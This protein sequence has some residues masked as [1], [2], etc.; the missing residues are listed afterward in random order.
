MGS[1][2][3]RVP[4]RMWW[5]FKKR[6]VRRKAWPWKKRSI[7]S[8]KKSK[9]RKLLSTLTTAS[10]KKSRKVEAYTKSEGQTCR[11]MAEEL[12]T[13]QMKSRLLT[14][15]SCGLKKKRQNAI[16]L[17]K[18]TRPN[19]KTT[20]KAE[21]RTSVHSMT[22]KMKKW[23]GKR[24]KSL[25]NQIQRARKKKLTKIKLDR[26]ST[27][28]KKV[29]KENRRLVTQLARVRS[30]SLLS[31]LEAPQRW[32]TH[33]STKS[34]N[35]A[36]LLWW[37]RSRSRSSVQSSF[38]VQ[39]P[40]HWLKVRWS[41]SNRKRTIRKSKRLSSIEITLSERDLKPNKSLRWSPLEREKLSMR[42]QSRKLKNPILSFSALKSTMKTHFLKLNGKHLHKWSMKC[43]D[44]AGSRSYQQDRRAHSPTNSTCFISFLATRFQ[45]MSFQSTYSSQMLFPTWR[46]A[47]RRRN[48]E[49][50]KLMQFRKHPVKKWKSKL[51]SAG[52]SWFLS[53]TLNI[54]SAVWTNRIGQMKM[55]YNQ[56]IWNV[57]NS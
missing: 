5:K 48:L 49:K 14:R 36:M 2:V 21:L 38:S 35:H 19:S 3:K 39:T 26:I 11:E 18:N 27:Q 41:A 52:C 56:S 50:S 34:R 47:R 43:K 32:M 16:S 53:T 12:W 29:R 45:L 8:C 40:I 25:H 57:P 13:F 55:E 31:M 9:R 7:S 54:A 51:T 10:S 30:K 33:I 22:L 15:S 44:S 17:S 6:C 4:K 24:C 42:R 28:M 46:S 37:K 23:R 20:L 1:S